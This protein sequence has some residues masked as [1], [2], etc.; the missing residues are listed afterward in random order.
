MLILKHNQ[1]TKGDCMIQI[2]RYSPM[3]FANKTG[4]ELMYKVEFSDSPLKS[5]ILFHGT[6]SACSEFI[7]QRKQLKIRHNRKN[8]RENRYLRTHKI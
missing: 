7:C 6:Y 8:R 4:P 3:Q 1:L 2:L 5:G